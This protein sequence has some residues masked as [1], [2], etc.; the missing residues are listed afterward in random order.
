M[1]LLFHHIPKTAGTTL[2]R[3]FSTSLGDRAYPHETNQVFQLLEDSSP[4]Y[5]HTMDPMVIASHRPYSEL[6]KLFPNRQSI[7]ILRDPTE[8]VLSFYRWLRTHPNSTAQDKNIKE[9]LSVVMSR[10]VADWERSHVDERM[11]RQLADELNVDKVCEIV[12]EMAWVGFQR[13]FNRDFHALWRQL[14]LPK[15]K[16]I[17]FNVTG[18]PYV[19]SAIEMDAIGEVTI[20]DQA[21]YDRLYHQFSNP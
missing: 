1:R 3:M 7:T 15:I 10:D 18:R 11:T 4:A 17:N 9:W 2:I 6:I 5:I 8:R 20:H 14:D 21:V 12:S 19:P 16:I 13:T